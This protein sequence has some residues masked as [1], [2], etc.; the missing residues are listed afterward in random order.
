MTALKTKRYTWNRLQQVMTAILLGWTKADVNRSLLAGGPAYLRVLGFSDKGR[1]LLKQMKKTA[2]LPIITRIS[3][4]RPS[5]LEWDIRAS[6]LYNLATGW[7]LPFMEEFRRTPV[8][9]RSDK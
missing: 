7:R 4:D 1:L 8:Y 9:V 2:T 6:R 5:M 3:K